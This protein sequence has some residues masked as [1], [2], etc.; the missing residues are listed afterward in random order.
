MVKHNSLNIYNV[1]SLSDVNGTLFPEFLV[2]VLIVRFHPLLGGHHGS[3]DLL[4]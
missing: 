1:S 3:L 2:H 4:E